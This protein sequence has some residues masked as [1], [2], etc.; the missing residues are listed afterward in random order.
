MKYCIIEG[1]LAKFYE[2][3]NSEAVVE[4]VKYSKG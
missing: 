1:R 4:T 3:K 2:N